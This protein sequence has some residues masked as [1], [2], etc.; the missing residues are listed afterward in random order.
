[1]MTDD[2]ILEVVAAHKEGKKIQSRVRGNG[3]RPEEGWGSPSDKPDWN[4][5]CW[6]YRVA[7]E[8]RE[9]KDWWLDFKNTHHAEVYSWNYGG[10]CVH[11][12]EVE[13]ATSGE[14]EVISSTVK[15]FP[16]AP[17]RKPREW[18]LHI[19]NEVLCSK[20]EGKASIYHMTSPG[21]SG[22]YVDGAQCVRVRE[23]LE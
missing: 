15:T 20:R 17:P 8:P 23:I 12:Q 11:V 7:P 14:P 21:H 9:R 10:D 5:Y 4:F 6:D 22:G 2:Q 16:Q 1:M 13:G 18:I 3:L 19:P